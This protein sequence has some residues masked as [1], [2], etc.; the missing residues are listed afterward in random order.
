MKNQEISYEESKDYFRSKK[1]SPP[2]EELFNETKTKV[3]KAIE[4]KKELEQKN[5]NK[6]LSKDLV[7]P[8]KTRKTRRSKKSEQSWM[9]R[10]FL[11][12]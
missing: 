11:L 1:V 4:A 2:N 3:L 6:A 10:L 7:K 5:S 12:H 9:D 8:K